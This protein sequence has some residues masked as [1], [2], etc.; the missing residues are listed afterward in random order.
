MFKRELFAQF[1]P[2]ALF[3]NVGRGELVN[4]AELIA[5]L[6]EGML[7]GAVLDVFDPEPVPADSPLWD[8]PN[9]IMTPHMSSD[10]A[11]TYAPRTLDLVFE[12]LGR[13]ASGEPLRN[14]VDPALGY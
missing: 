14:R 2:S 4:E 10:D 9:L 1:N 11:L 12:N 8:T 7:S 5:A 6:D 3:I 13:L